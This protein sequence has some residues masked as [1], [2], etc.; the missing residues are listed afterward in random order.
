MH[1]ESKELEIQKKLDGN[2]S[3]SMDVKNTPETVLPPFM[4]DQHVGYKVETPRPGSGQNLSP[5]VQEN[6]E[7][8]KEL[9]LE[10]KPEPTEVPQTVETSPQADPKKPEESQTKKIEKPIELENKP[11]SPEAPITKNIV[12]DPPK[13]KDENDMEASLDTIKA[14]VPASKAQ[15][16]GQEMEDTY[17]L[18]NCS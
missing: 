9:I 5:E 17:G 14:P 4:D 16:N 7:A 2:K 13:V 11:I 6:Q 1:A 12:L 8:K 18:S 3:G 15:P 10:A